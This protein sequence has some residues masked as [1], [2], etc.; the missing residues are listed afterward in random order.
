MPVLSSRREDSL[1]EERN[2]SEYIGASSVADEEDLGHSGVEFSLLSGK[3]GGR[4]CID[5][6]EIWGSGGLG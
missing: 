5:V 2:S 1:S 4:R 3:Q 6:E